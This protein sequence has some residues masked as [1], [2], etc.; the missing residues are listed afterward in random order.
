MAGEPMSCT[1]CG[2]NYYENEGDLKVTLAK[3]VY[4]NVQSV[5]KSSYQYET[6]DMMVQRCANCYKNHKPVTN[7]YG[8]YRFFSGILYY[9]TI[10]I[11]VILAIGGIG[12][13]I[14][15]GSSVDFIRGLLAV[16]V[17]AGLIFGK[18]AIDGAIL[19]KLEAQLN[20]DGNKKTYT[21][22]SM[23][24]SIEKDPKISEILKLH[25][26]YDSY[27]IVY[28]SLPNF[29]RRAG[30]VHYEKRVNEIAKESK[31]EYARDIIKTRMNLKI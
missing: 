9:P 20:V 13:G 19:K 31:T 15:D 16:V 21:F 17:S 27:F 8:I 1:F 14:D 4:A 26:I 22:D 30:K 11:A 25:D 18:K 6:V 12:I 7:S 5:G 2:A 23:V 28:K 29:L 3:C 10:I 24:T